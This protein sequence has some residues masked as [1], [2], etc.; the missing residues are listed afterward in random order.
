MADDQISNIIEFPQ[1]RG[2]LYS[3]EAMKEAFGNLG[4]PQWPGI[5][6]YA[7]SNPHSVAAQSIHELGSI[8]DLSRL[9]S[10]W[11]N[12]SSKKVS[13]WKAVTEVVRGSVRAQDF[14]S[15]PKYDKLIN[16]LRRA[17]AGEPVALNLRYPLNAE[18]KQRLVT[19]LQTAQEERRLLLAREHAIAAEKAV[20]QALK[21]QKQGEAKAQAAEAEALANQAA[22]STRLSEIEGLV[23]I[24]RWRS[25]LSIIDGCDPVSRLIKSRISPEDVEAAQQWDTRYREE[26]AV[27]RAAREKQKAA[28]AVKEGQMV[29]IPKFRHIQV[30]RTK[31][32][33]HATFEAT[34]RMTLKS[35]SRR[36]SLIYTARSRLTKH[37]IDCGK[38][39]DRIDAECSLQNFKK[40]FEVLVVLDQELEDCL[41]SSMRPLEVEQ[42]LGITARERLKWT[43]DGRLPTDG[44]DSFRKGGVTITFSLH[45][46]SSIAAINPETVETWRQE[47]KD[48]TKAARSVGAKKAGSTRLRNDETRKAVR[49]NLDKMAREASL[50]VLSPIAVPLVKLAFLTTICSRWAKSRRDKG[51]PTGE[52]EFYKLKDRALKVISRQPWSSVRFIPSEVPRLDV[53]LCEP[54]MSDFR[55]DRRAYQA[56]FPEWIEDN[57]NVVRRCNGCSYREDRDYYALY[58]VRLAVGKAEFC[59]HIPYSLG[60]EWLPGKKEIESGPPRSGDDGIVL[61]GRPVNDH[62][63]IVWK[64]KKLAEEMNVLLKLFSEGEVA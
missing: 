60:R 11:K 3:V 48:V 52:S 16:A 33:F 64:P 34:E 36:S 14:V 12:K 19:F 28:D 44:T 26:L 24:K 2:E 10:N 9:V 7:K 35:V 15:R 62:E 40:F 31:T 43:K 27:K 61:F 47:D 22:A 41:K 5:L 8:E 17:I 63:I 46:Y 54:H 21:S 1:G 59:W 42:A 6:S 38:M 53:H 37:R 39:S 51:D 55:D 57:V 20:Q 50:H 32:C 23:G 58:E 4:H 25:V 30:S 45:P 18:E 56:S 29:K 49:D 13:T